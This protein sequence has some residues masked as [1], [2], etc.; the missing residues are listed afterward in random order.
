MRTLA[1][2]MMI[3]GVTSTAHADLK[4]KTVEYTHD[5]TTFVGYLAYDDAV[6][7]DKTP[8]PGVIVCPEWWGNDDYAHMRAEMLAREGYVAL[9]IDL[10]GKNEKGE[11]RTTSDPQQAAKW[12]GEVNA[13][14][15]VMRE[16]ALAGYNT[17][18]TQKFVDR[19]HVAAI[20]YCMGGT[21]ALELARAG[22]DLEAVVAFHA[23]RIAA[24]NPADN[25]KLADAGTT[26]LICHGQEDTFVK[27][28]EIPAF[29]TQMKEAGVDYE[30]VSYAGA[31]HS[32]T[33]KKADSHNMPG[34]KYDEKAD[35][36]SW[37][38]TLALFNEK[39]GKGK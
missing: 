6:A 34:V 14:A 26:V 7:T 36:R 22:A 17:L 16:R 38:R 32:F 13:D 35:K 12:A 21:V 9:A 28:E 1:L 5:G 37:A 27:P 20:G 24:A 18:V 3:L 23:S 2:A 39:L 4:T 33:N 11:A 31:V 15:K 8:R 25:K 19:T 30:F 10:Y 29:H